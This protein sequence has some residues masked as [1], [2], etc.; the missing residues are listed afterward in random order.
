MLVIYAGEEVGEKYALK[1]GEVNR[2]QVS[3][4]IAALRGNSDRCAW[5]CK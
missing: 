4:L 1:V 3:A 2:D 5:R